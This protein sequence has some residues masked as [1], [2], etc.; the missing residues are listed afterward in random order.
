[1]AAVI[2]SITDLQNLPNLQTFN[3][4]FNGLQSVNL[5]G[6]TSLLNVDISDNNIPGGSTN[7]LTSVNLSGSTAVEELLLDGSDFSAGIPSL[8]GLTSLSIIDFDQCSISGVV[9]LSGLSVL[10]ELDFSG[11]T[12]LTS[13][14]IA[15]TQPI[16]NFYGNNCAL[17]ETA[18]DDILVTLSNSI[19]SSG[20]VNITGA[21]N[22]FPSATG[23]AAKITLRD[24]KNW[25]VQVREPLLPFDVTADWSL[26]TPAVTDEATFRTFLESGGSGGVNSLTNVNITAFSLVGNRLQCNLSANNSPGADLYLAGMNITSVNSLGNMIDRIDQ[27]ILADNNIASVDGVVWPY[28]NTIDLSIND[29]TSVNNITWPFG[30]INLYLN[31]NQIVNFNPTVA[32]PSGLQYL[33]LSVNQIV[34]FNPSIALPNSLDIL[35]IENNY[36][37][38]FNP[39]IPLPTGLYAL[40]LGDNQMTTAGYTASEPWANTMPVGSGSDS[41]YF[42]SNVDSV[43]GT[44]LETILIAKGWSVY[45]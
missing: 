40:R 37:V 10:T 1:M 30:L 6:L 20:F 35:D 16:S 44:T 42:T 28:A 15:D 14:I 4:E 8:V 11:N 22:A 45:G 19:V 32:L 9:D 31:E 38:I 17:T 25:N 2:T 5:S 41:V 12:A 13:I 43:S 3:A 24:G 18:V 29:I 39:T 27:L 23:F 21:T 34:T 36:I 7:S 26:L 33:N